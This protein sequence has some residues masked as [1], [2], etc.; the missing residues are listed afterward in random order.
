MRATKRIVTGAL[1]TPL[2]AALD[3]AAL[4]FAGLLRHGA[5][6]EGI[7]ASRDTRPP[8]WEAAMPR[9]PNFL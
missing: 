5:A 2:P 8:S 3:A 1:E 6:R 9:L 4:E 7:A